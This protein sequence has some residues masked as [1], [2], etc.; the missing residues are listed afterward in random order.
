M[1]TDIVRLLISG[2]WS[3]ERARQ[4]ARGRLR[5]IAE[6][7]RLWSPRSSATRRSFVNEPP[8]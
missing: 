6:L 8:M 7:V 4:T 1:K 2:R 3:L 5:I